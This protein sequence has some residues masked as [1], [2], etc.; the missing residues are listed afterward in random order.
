MILFGNKQ[1]DDR[2]LKI[3][4]AATGNGTGVATLRFEVSQTMTVTLDGAARFYTDSGGTQNE[5]TSWT[6]TVGAVRTIYVKCTSGSANLTIPNKY[7][8]TKWGGSAGDG[9]NSPTNGASL[10]ISNILISSFPNITQLRVTTTASV[11][12]TGAPPAALTWWYFAGNN[13]NYTYSGDPTTG[14]TFW[15]FLGNN[16]RFTYSGAPPTGLTDWYLYGANIN[17]TSLTMPSGNNM[18]SLYLS[19]WRTTKLT[20]FEMINIL[21]NL[22][23]RVGNLPSSITIGDYLNYANPPQSVLDAKAALIAAGKGTTTVNLTA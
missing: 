21:N 7:L 12:L 3:L 9:W 6:I 22:T 20:D 11:T 14:L 13:I 18:S 17:C 5:S 1:I 15:V 2:Q 10:T 8:I 19:N 16:I 4:L 23:N